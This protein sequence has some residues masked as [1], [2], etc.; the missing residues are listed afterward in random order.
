MSALSDAIMTSVTASLDPMH[1]MTRQ[2]M[3]TI[4][5]EKRGDLLDRKAERI[6]RIGQK[7]AEA[8][9]AI[10]NGS[11]SQSTLDSLKRLQAAMEK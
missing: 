4:I 5:E 9:D 3:E 11:G 7:I 1:G 10:K 2:Y 8:Q 6:E